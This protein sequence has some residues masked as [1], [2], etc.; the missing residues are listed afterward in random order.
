MMVMRDVY[1]CWSW[2]QRLHILN[3]AVASHVP[4]VH[5]TGVIQLIIVA[6]LLVLLA[7]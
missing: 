4:C 2:A 7:C 1:E 6:G 3:S 5:V